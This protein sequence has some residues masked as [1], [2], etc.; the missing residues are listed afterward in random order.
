MSNSGKKAMGLAIV[1]FIITGLV[2]L[3]INTKQSTWNSI[4]PYIGMAQQEDFTDSAFEGNGKWYG[5]CDK[6]SIRSI[7]DFR[8]AV[9]RDPALKIHYATFNWQNARI[10][11]LEHA[12]MAYVYF[13]KDGQIF[14]KE[15]P[16]KL[17]AGDEYI[18]D[19]DTRVRTHCCNSYVLASETEAVQPALYHPSVP[20]PATILFVALGIAGLGAGNMIFRKGMARR[21]RR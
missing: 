6:N 17:V 2:V 12:V 4:R 3:T 8:A 16:I 11:R 9:N 20:E 10:G 15:K 19:G 21:K 7:E 5:L 14:R 18:T 1:F 13:K